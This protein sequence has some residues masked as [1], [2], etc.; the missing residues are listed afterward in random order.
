MLRYLLG[1]KL[2]EAITLFT[3][4]RMGFP[5]ILLP[6]QLLLITLV[7][8][9]LPALILGL[10]SA[11][12]GY[13]GGRGIYWVLMRGVLMGITPPAAFILFYSA[14]QNILSA[15]TAALLTLTL[16]QLLYALEEGRG[17]AIRAKGDL[18]GPGLWGGIICALGMAV[19]GVY[20][21]ALQRIFGTVSLTGGELALVL[22]LCAIVPLATAL[23]A[24][25][26]RKG[27]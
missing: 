18:S 24:E 16:S 23:I 14:T 13:F 26:S 2:G 11:R 3:G 5:D 17:K 10:S 4:L 9:G 22:V 20:L 12:E 8:N 27:E 1:C 21:P 19:G 15:R 7:G 6:R 25:A